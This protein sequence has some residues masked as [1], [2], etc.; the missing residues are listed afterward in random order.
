MKEREDCF[1][2]FRANQLVRHENSRYNNPY[3]YR[4]SC[5]LESHFF[6]YNPKENSREDRNHKLCRN[7]LKVLIQ[8]LFAFI[9][10]IGSTDSQKGYDHDDNT[11]V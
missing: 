6:T 2:C 4:N 5:R 7:G 11:P 8:T 3:N 10:H 1:A 9:N